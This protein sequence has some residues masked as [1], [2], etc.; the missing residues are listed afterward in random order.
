MC[1]YNIFCKKLTLMSM[2]LNLVFVPVTQSF[3]IDS[4]HHASPY[5]QIQGHTSRITTTSSSTPLQMRFVDIMAQRKKLRGKNKC[6]IFAVKK[7]YD[8]ET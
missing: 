4:S 8:Y 6:F 5:R 7:F 2:T 1:I 3:S